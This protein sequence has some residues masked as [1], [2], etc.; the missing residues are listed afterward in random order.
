MLLR[1]MALLAV[2]ATAAA[3]DR[4]EPQPGL[5]PAS[6]WK[7][8]AA[9]PS[10]VEGGGRGK[11]RSPRGSASHRLEDG[12]GAAAEEGE[13]QAADEDPHGPDPD[14]G[15]DG[16][17]EGE[18]EE[19]DLGPRETVAKGR[20]RAA[21]EASA[22]V[23]PGAVIYVSAVP[24]DGSGQPTGSAIAVDRFEVKQLPM[25]FELEGAAFTGEVVITAWTDQDG[26]ARTREPGD[27][28]GRVRARLPA[29]GI[30]L[31]LDKVLK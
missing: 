6:E 8:P 29:T 4:G 28:E 3:C 20:I 12:P 19:Q 22:A 11:A 23:A 9:K 21:G 27:A 16:E 24:V 5:P 15:E 13:E 1:R 30:D 25:E 31:V 18:E 17:A 14:H 26:E 7:P 2:V 10:K